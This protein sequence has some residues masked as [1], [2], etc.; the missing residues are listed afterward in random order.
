MPLIAFGTR[1]V[2]RNCRCLV[3]ITL[4][5]IGLVVSSL[6]DQLLS[7][8]T[9]SSPIGTPSML[10]YPRALSSPLFIL[11]INDL[12]T[13]ASSSIHSFADDTFLCSTF[14]FNQNDHASSDIPFHRN[15]SIS[16]LS[17]DLTII[18]KWG[19]DSL[20]FS[21][22]ARRNR[23]SFHANVIKTFQLSS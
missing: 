5:L 6:I 20:V 23:L 4:S 15:S 9:A 1:V 3:S 13:S 18:E 22:K 12:L 17:N 21:T 10:V 14:S 19:L 16:R 2:S 8:W 11:F 7:E